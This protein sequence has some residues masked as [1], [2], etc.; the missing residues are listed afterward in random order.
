M[1][2][3]IMK[4]LSCAVLSMNIRTYATVI[5]IKMGKGSMYEALRPIA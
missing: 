4:M 2:M 5:G 3:L 1:L